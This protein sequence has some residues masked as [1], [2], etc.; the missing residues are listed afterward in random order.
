MEKGA[1]ANVVTPADGEG[2]YPSFMNATQAGSSQPFWYPSLPASEFQT[3]A[4]RP[5]LL[6]IPTL[7]NPQH[8]SANALITPPAEQ[9]STSSVP[10]QSA[11][12]V[13]PNLAG[14]LHSP[15]KRKLSG[16]EEVADE[17][18]E[19]DE[20]KKTSHNKIEKRYRYN[21]NSKISELKQCVPSLRAIDNP[22]GDEDLEGLAPAHKTNKATVLLKTIEYIKHLEKQNESLKNETVYLKSRITTYEK[23]MAGGMMPFHSPAPEASL[24][25]V[26]P[27]F[28]IHSESSLG[29]VYP[30][31]SRPSS[32]QSQTIPSY[33]YSGGAPQAGQLQQGVVRA[34]GII[35][36]PNDLMNIRR[37][38]M[39]QPP[40]GVNQGFSAYPQT[41]PMQPT[42]SGGGVKAT[43]LGK[44]II[45]GITTLLVVDTFY[46]ET[47]D[48]E[49]LQKRSIGSRL[50]KS[51]SV[52]DLF[53]VL[54]VILICVAM[55]YLVFPL[56][57][58]WYYSMT[59]CHMDTT[60]IVAEGG[61]ILVKRR[62]WI[63]EKWLQKEE[64]A[65]PDLEN[66]VL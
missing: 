44:A 23:M 6:N 36:V 50:H 58:S 51:C 5:Q 40:Y 64:R 41:T 45:G 7:S 39:N 14:S 33:S 26:S 53:F 54:R 25:S 11:A 35:P 43:K 22:T 56:I 63:P 9:T 66:A 48:S 21:I 19:D 24:P 65:D 13:S 8:F 31:H 20:S 34:E 55:S 38:Q 18:D 32:S 28:S 2:S 42:A 47:K 30:M 61:L 4:S 1:P 16:P 62:T 59:S 37:S 46:S 60:P 52:L 27:N 10:H 12:S 3:Q 49:A 17:D 29:T 57:W 15:R